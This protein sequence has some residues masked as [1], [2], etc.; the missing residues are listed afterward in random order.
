MAL[1]KEAIFAGTFDPFTLGHLAVVK[2]A[3]KTFNKVIILLAINDKKKPTYSLKERKKFIELSTKGLKGVVIDYTDGYVVDYAKK[4]CINILIR[5]IRNE[6]DYEYEAK[7]SK[8]NQK[9]APDIMTVAINATARYRD[10][11]SSKVKALKQKGEDL[12]PYV[13]KTIIKYL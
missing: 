2:Q 11:S 13:A 1:K 7:M 6:K 12:S 4:H 8:I 9:L 10:I 3:L 5:G